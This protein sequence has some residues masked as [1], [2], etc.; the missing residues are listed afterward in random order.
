MCG[1][2]HVV[3]SLNTL[4][5]LV[6]SSDILIVR[7]NLLCSISNNNISSSLLSEI[8]RIVNLPKSERVA[9]AKQHQ[10]LQSM[11]QNMRSVIAMVGR[12]HTGKSACLRAIQGLPLLE[13]L[14]STRGADHKTLSVS[15]TVLEYSK[16]CLFMQ[17][18]T[19]MSN[20]IRWMNGPRADDGIHTHTNLVFSRVYPD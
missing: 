1:D 15:R 9:L 19:M 17:H 12:G 14:K 18:H 7:V 4:S 10:N 2:Y 20:A 13:D 11:A 5:C 3:I 8:S 16:Q 6:I